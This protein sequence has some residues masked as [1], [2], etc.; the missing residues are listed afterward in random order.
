MRPG[1]SER[2]HT[3]AM[4]K[5]DQILLFCYFLLFLGVFLHISFSCLG[6]PCFPWRFSC[7]LSW[8]TI[9]AWGFWVGRCLRRSTRVFVTVY[10]LLFFLFFNG[11]PAWRTKP[12]QRQHKPPIEAAVWGLQLP[13]LSRLVRALQLHACLSW[14]WHLQKKRKDRNRKMK[15]WGA[16]AQ[17]APAVI[18]HVAAIHASHS[19]AFP[20]YASHFRACLVTYRMRQAAP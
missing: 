19:R 11:L 4:Q 2:Y 9:V 1:Y 12:R 6:L 14:A 18:P 10:L 8:F 13:Y 17:A 5:T 16:P 20:A 15:H 3:G 7:K